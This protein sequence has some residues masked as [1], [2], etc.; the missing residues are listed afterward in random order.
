MRNKYKKTLKQISLNKIQG[1][2]PEIVKTVAI[3]ANCNFIRRMDVLSDDAIFQLL[4]IHP[5]FLNKVSD[6]YHVVGGFRSYQLALANVNEELKVTCHIY[7]N[8][9]KEKIV[10]IAQI[11]LLGSVILHSLGSKSVAQIEAII[12]D[13]GSDAANKIAPG[14]NSTRAIT[15]FEKIK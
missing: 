15:R 4:N 2:H 6:K 1:Y 5:I 7:N 3:L 12:S 9:P 10:E 13:I 11:D 8:L 14:L